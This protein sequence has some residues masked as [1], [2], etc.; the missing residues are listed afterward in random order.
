VVL[1]HG[2]QEGIEPSVAGQRRRRDRQGDAE[3]AL[4]SGEVVIELEEPSEG[5]TLV[6]GG[7]R[8][9]DVVGR[10]GCRWRPRRQ[11]SKS[12]AN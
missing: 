12:P 5:S 6:A 7:E 3:G 11:Q 2:G 10:V 4:G 8:R 9:S 1:D